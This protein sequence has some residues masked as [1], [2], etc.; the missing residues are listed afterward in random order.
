LL[1]KNN[2]FRPKILPYSSACLELEELSFIPFR[3]EFEMPAIVRVGD[4]IQFNP[5]ASTSGALQYLWEFGDNRHSNS[6][7]KVP[8]FRYDSIGAYPVKLR[9]LTRKSD[10]FIT[11]SI[12]K[13][14]RVLPV[15]ER[16]ERTDVFGNNFS[17]EIG[18]EIKSLPDN[19]GFLLLGKK[20][21]NTLTSLTWMKI[22]S[23]AGKRRSTILPA[24]R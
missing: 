21:I 18:L 5:S 3:A 13:T 17:D 22:W 14:I 11:D 7:E 20:D 6:V 23:F 16:P 12:Q 8:R 9:V 2:Y 24:G 4:T 10:G 19:L 1:F 15:T